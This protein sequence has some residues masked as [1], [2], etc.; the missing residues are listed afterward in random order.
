MSTVFATVA[1]KELSCLGKSSD[2]PI[3]ESSVPVCS[4]SVQRSDRYIDVKI[5]LKEGIAS[6]PILRGG[7][8]A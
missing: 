8:L 3:S 4:Y 7:N 1:V 5:T 6:C 2:R